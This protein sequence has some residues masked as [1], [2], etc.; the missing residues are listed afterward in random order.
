M[1]TL[2]H[3]LRHAAIN[4]LVYEYGAPELTGGKEERIMDYFDQT[5]RKQA[6]KNN[7][8]VSPV[9]PYKVV[10]ER[11]E[12]AARLYKKEAKLYN[13]LASEVLKLRGVPLRAKPEE[14]GWLQKTIDT[15]FN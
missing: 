4:Y 15:L 6:S 11:G 1:L 9:S 5:N 10:A 13:E 2:A 7:R 3:E 8:L 12:S 14:K